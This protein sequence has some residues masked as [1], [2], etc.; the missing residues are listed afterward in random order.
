VSY[1]V[2]AARDLRQHISE[3]FIVLNIEMFHVFEAYVTV[4]SIYGQDYQLTSTFPQTE[5]KDYP[6]NEG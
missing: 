5:L 6:A 2:Q 4:Q 3:A 1:L